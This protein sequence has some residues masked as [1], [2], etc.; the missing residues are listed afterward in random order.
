MKK[1]LQI[2]CLLVFSL[3][4][5]IYA[6]YPRWVSIAGAKNSDGFNKILEIRETISARASRTYRLTAADPAQ[7]CSLQVSISNPAALGEKDVLNLTLRSG[8][9]VI[10]S[11]TLH[12]GD[13]DL[14]LSFRAINNDSRLEVVSSAGTPIEF[15]G[16]VLVWPQSQSAATILE[17]EPNDSWGEADEIT[18]GQTV[19]ATADDKPYIV[20]SGRTQSQADRLPYQQ[21]TASAETASGDLMPEGGIDWYKFNYNGEGT[22]LIHFEIDLLERDNLPVDVS[23]YRLEGGQARIYEEGIDPISPPHEVQALPGNKFTTRLISR[24]T[25]YL[26]VDANHPFYRL[27]TAIYDP[28]PYPDP[29]QAVRAGMDYIISAGDSWHANTPRH[30]GIV[31]RVSSAHAETQLCIACHATHFSTR[32]EL[33]AAHNGY[34]VARRSSLEFLIERLSNNP[35]PFYGHTEAYWTRVIS[36][37]ANV[38]SRLASLVDQYEKEFDARRR[39]GL[40]TG[41]GNYLKLYYKGRTVL[42]G[43]ETNGNTPLVSTYEVAWYS[44]KVF[45]RL[46]RETGDAGWREYRDQVR[47]LIEQDAH[48]NLIDLC[49]QTIAMTEI[50][51]S[52]YA[53]KIRRN[54]ERILSLQ[55]DDGQWSMLFEPASTPVEF[56]TYHCLYTL[57]LA[58]YQPEDPRIAKSIKFLLGR[59]QSFGGWFDPRQTY[60]NFRTPFRETQFAVMALSQFY[61]ERPAADKSSRVNLAGLGPVSRLEAIDSVWDRPAQTMVRELI[62]NLG[63]EEPMLRMAAAA[64]LGRTGAAEAE[65]QLAG[66]LG[67]R[68]K[69]VQIATAQALRRLPGKNSDGLILSALNSRDERVRW[70]ATRIFAQHFASLAAQTGSADRLINLMSD[71]YVMVRMQ[72]VKSLMQW[73]WWTRDESL[74][75]R[76]ADAFIARMA[77]AEHPWVR[78]NLVENFY[79]LADENVR[80]LYNNWIAL[81]AQPDD[82]ERARQGH[83]EASRRMAERVAGVLVSG[84][85]L[86]REGMLQAITEFHLRSGGYANAGRYT[87]IGNDIETIKFYEEGAPGM[88]RALLPLLSSNNRLTRKRAVLAAYTLREN[89]LDE[90]PLQVLKRLLDQSPEV[91]AVADEFYRSLPLEVRERNRQEAV[92]ILRELLASDRAEAQ[93]AALERIKSLGADFARR[94]NFDEQIRRFAL[95]ADLKVAPAALRALADFPHL[96]GDEAL[97]GRVAAALRSSNPEMIRSAWQLTSSR[98]EWRGERTIAAAVDELLTTSETGKRRLIL[99]M[100]GEGTPVVEDERLLNL[101]IGSLG[102]KNEQLRA[103]ALSAVRRVKGLS[104]HTAVRSAIAVIAAD[105]NERLQE[106]AIALYEGEARRSAGPT[107]TLDYEFFVQ[108]VMPLLAAKGRDGNACVN[109][110][111][112]HTILKLTPPDAAGRLAESQLRENYASASRVVDRANPENSLILRKPTSDAA[113][114]GVVGSKRIPHGGGQRWT[115]IDDPAYRTVLDWINGARI[116]R[117]D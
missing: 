114:E 34:N 71:P 75:W 92:L 48:K 16:V 39:A 110:H 43:D 115:G 15:S 85:D 77:V 27:R 58:G 70:G 18:L 65:P 61:K 64:A 82:R 30:G 59:Q 13:P 41:V 8:E 35:R 10:T 63:S 3:V 91:R 66:L 9:K 62:S 103:A 40:L 20:A 108:R 38:M 79:S 56:Q 26:R 6:I 7:T 28:P 73:F 80:Y 54:A 96:A 78:R 74:Q 52:A 25:Y 83:H 1:K 33:T 5:S 50:D 51:R 45:D 104:A 53:G 100:L 69:L 94:E 23:I 47:R 113:Q 72:A 86:Q 93:I 89:S 116:N 37:S 88:E 55:R 102:D 105:P 111:F 107:R 19:W 31:N 22:R 12:A 44:W 49:Y 112:N 24:G 101:I 17:S 68:S 87:R 14:Y 76:I 90:L 67:D 117:Q 32:A 60:E 109:C 36:A 29:R 84:N 99:G 11:K 2:G 42:P 81:L 21:T 95:N 97:Q 98:P 46:S 4:A 57:A 106:Q